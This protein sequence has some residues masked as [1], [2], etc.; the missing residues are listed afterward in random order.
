[1]DALSTNDIFPPQAIAFGPPNLMSSQCQIETIV[2][3]RKPQA[4]DML[5]RLS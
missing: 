2:S 3:L 5:N 1:M 4:K